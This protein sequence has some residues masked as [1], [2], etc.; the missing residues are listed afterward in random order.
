MRVM[1]VLTI[2]S[3]Y[4]RKQFENFTDVERLRVYGDPVVLTWAIFG[5][6]SDPHSIVLL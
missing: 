2:A 5:G 4:N 1:H 3:G 6:K